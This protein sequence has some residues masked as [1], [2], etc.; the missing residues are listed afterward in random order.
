M[1]TPTLAAPSVAIA[2]AR[3]LHLDALRGAA[4]LLMVVDHVALFADVPE[5]RWTA[6]RLAMPLFFILG[7][8]LA[9]R[10][11]WRTLLLVPAVGLGVEFV[12][13]W[14]GAGAL[15]VSFAVGAAAVVLLRRYAPWALW[16]IVALALTS[17]ANG[18]VSVDS[19]YDPGQLSALMALG[20]LLT[21][22]QLVG[23]L[24]W[25]PRPALV[26]LAQAG[27]YPLSLYAGQAVLLTLIFA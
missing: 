23:L 14:T 24:R 19:G 27:R 7:G 5:V 11:S 15:L 25:V 10:F 8:H 13:P 18:R 4:V 21:R 6:G 1:T 26:R 16:L 3:S 17:A 20:A 9:C 2:G 12:A 22:H